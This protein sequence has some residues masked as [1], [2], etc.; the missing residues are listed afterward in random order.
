MAGAL[1]RDGESRP[2]GVECGAGVSPCRR[3][4]QRGRVGPAGPAGRP[5]L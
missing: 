4:G 5:G 1:S 2:F 3:E